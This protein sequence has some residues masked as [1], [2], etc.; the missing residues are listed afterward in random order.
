MNL[1]EVTKNF[2]WTEDRKFYFNPSADEYF[3]LVDYLNTFPLAYIDEEISNLTKMQTFIVANDPER[4]HDYIM[5]ELA[6]FEDYNGEEYVCIGGDTQFRSRLLYDLDANNTFLY[7]NYG[8]YGKFYITLPE[9]IH[10]LL[11]KK[12]LLQTLISL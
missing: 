10:L 9:A 12:A 5:N 6:G 8:D 3:L 7:P 4:T 11:Q 1:L 2:F